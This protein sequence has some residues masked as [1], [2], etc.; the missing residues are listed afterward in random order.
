M[1]KKLRVLVFANLILIVLFAVLLN[2]FQWQM[3]GD[4][5]LKRTTWSPLMISVQDYYVLEGT[6]VADGTTIY[7]NTP[8]ILLCVIIALNVFFAL[9]LYRQS[10]KTQNDVRS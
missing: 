1:S 2:Y 4:S 9:E 7:V 6:L 3:L 10:K 8:F 5:A